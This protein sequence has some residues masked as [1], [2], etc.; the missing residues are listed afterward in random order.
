MN[1]DVK[2]KVVNGLVKLGV[3]DSANEPHLYIVW[4]EELGEKEKEEIW[5]DINSFAWIP[6][7]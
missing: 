7:L 2:K 5:R 3:R 4:I 1:R 6:I